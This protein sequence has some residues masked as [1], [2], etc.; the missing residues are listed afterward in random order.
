MNR[1]QGIPEDNP[2]F[3]TLNPPREPAAGAPDAHRG[4]RASRCSTRRRCARS[5]SSGRCRGSGAPGSAAPTSA[6]ASMR[7]A[8]I[9]PGRG[10]S[11]RAAC[12]GPGPCQRVRAASTCRPARADRACP[13]QRARRCTRAASCT[14]GCGRAAPPALPRVLAAARHRRA[15]ASCTAAAA[16]LAESP[17]TCSASTSRPRR[18]RAAACAPRSMAGWRGRPPTGRRRDP[19]AVHAA[20][21]RLRLQSRSASISAIAATA[22]C[23]PILYEVNNTFG[24]APPYL[25]P[26]ERRRRADGAD[27]AALREAHARLALHRH[28]HAL[29]FTHRAAVGAGWR[30]DVGG[31]DVHDAEGRCCSPA[32][33]RP[34]RVRSPTRAAGRFLRIRCS[35]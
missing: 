35:R 11:A 10:R 13:M 8:A 27:P 5:A 30:R 7:T 2:L 26:V 29:R 20:H 32:S 25:L 19:A 12:G 28:G 21:P 3:V 18:R 9:G 16:V 23:R 31:I 4:L 34:R 1:L 17:P 22:R 6:P 33:R 14:S 15:A 24:E